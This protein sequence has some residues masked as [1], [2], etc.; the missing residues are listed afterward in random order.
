MGKAPRRPGP[1]TARTFPILPTSEMPVMPIQVVLPVATSTATSAINKPY[2]N[3]W[4]GSPLARIGIQFRT[5]AR[6]VIH[7]EVL[8]GNA[9]GDHFVM[10]AIGA[11][12]FSHGVH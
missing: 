9:L 8:G 10:G 1:S 11:V 7:A 6:R 3:A 5:S 2:I 4:V 12:G